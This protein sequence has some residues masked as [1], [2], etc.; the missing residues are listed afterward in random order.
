[1][2]IAK[3]VCTAMYLA[4]IEKNWLT[5]QRVLETRQIR[6]RVQITTRKVDS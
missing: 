1:M 6:E 2:Q 4:S 3:P 5:F